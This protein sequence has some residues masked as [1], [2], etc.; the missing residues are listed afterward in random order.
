M[1]SFN[2]LVLTTVL[3]AIQRG[4]ARV[5]VDPN[6]CQGDIRG[7]MEQALSDMSFMANIAYQCTVGLRDNTPS[8][9]NQDVVLNTF[10]TYFGLA[11]NNYLGSRGD[12]VLC[13]YI[14]HF[15]NM[16]PNIL[17]YCS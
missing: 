14:C 12:V 6:S 16:Q 4:K 7:K 5:T 1:P 13:T 17:N 11:E 3:L 2:L 8:P 10:Q 15:S 9:C